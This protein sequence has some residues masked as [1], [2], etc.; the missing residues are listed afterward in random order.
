[1][2]HDRRLKFCGC[3]NCV[4]KKATEH[5]VADAECG[6]QWQCACS[7][8]TR[9]RDAPGG[10]VHVAFARLQYFERKLAHVR[11]I[12]ALLVLA[13]IFAAACVVGGTALAVGSGLRRALAWSR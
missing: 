1:M 8:C 5:G 9:V 2:K 6:R 7:A 4:I 13:L 12:K 10:A 3:D 11:D